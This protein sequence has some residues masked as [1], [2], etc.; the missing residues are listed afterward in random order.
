MMTRRIKVPRA[1]NVQQV[2]EGLR[3]S[4]MGKSGG[5][6]TQHFR[7]LTCRLLANSAYHV[8]PAR[9]LQV[10]AEDAALPHPA[11]TWPHLQLKSVYN[12]NL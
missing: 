8:Y 3:F 6:N 2:D 11:L 10:L 9:T 4:N 7:P 1:A 12:A 5:C